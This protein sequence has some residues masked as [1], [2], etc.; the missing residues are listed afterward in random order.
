MDLR[1]DLSEIEA[2]LGQIEPSV[3]L[4]KWVQSVFHSQAAARQNPAVIRQEQRGALTVAEAHLVCC[5][6]LVSVRCPGS[7]RG[8]HG[9]CYTW[10][11]PAFM[12]AFSYLSPTP[13]DRPQ[14]IGLSALTPEGSA[15]FLA[16]WTCCRNERERRGIYGDS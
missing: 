9:G 11:F 4:W 16:Y 2:T 13:T 10:S 5:G 14:Y 6:F 15:P 3:D 7:Y 8:C 1:I 12:M